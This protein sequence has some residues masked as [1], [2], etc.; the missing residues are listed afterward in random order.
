[1]NKLDK[2][3][4]QQID[5]NQTKN[6]LYDQLGQIMEIDPDFLAAL[7]E[8]LVSDQQALSE[9]ALQ[10]AISFASEMLVRRLYS[11]NQFIQVGE[12][13]KRQ[14]ESIYLHTWQRIFETKDIQGTLKEDHYPALTNWIASLY[15]P[16][17]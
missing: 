6:M 8:L 12:Q 16:S 14:L 9:P 7:E 11:V 1:M 10:G 3:L 17:F 4:Q 13:K 5:R 2:A 15:P